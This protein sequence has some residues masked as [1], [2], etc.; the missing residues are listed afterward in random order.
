VDGGAF[1]RIVASDAGPAG[2]AHPDC[3][4]TVRNAWAALFAAV[5]GGGDE[6]DRPASPRP[7]PSPA[8]RAAAAALRLCQGVRLATRADAEGL[9]D[10]LSGAFDYLAMGDYPHPSSYITNGDGLLPAYPM[11]AACEAAV[12]GRRHPITGPAALAALADAV[13][14]FYNFSGALPCYDPGAGGDSASTDAD[15][16]LWGYQACTEQVMPMWRDGVADLGP[17]APWDGDAF[18][19]ACLATYGVTPRPEW[20]AIQWGGRRLDGLTNVA[21]TNGDLDPWSGTGVTGA[22]AA[23]AGL[24]RQSPTL[25]V[26]P[27]PG[28]AHHL[29]LMFSTPAD[30]PAV[31]AARATTREHMRRWVTEARGRRVLPGGG[32]GVAVA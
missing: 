17:A 27:V 7:K 4:D 32:E 10:F 14:V 24:D 8:A 2:G 6:G 13:G 20:A 3:G 26:V 15:G 11:R 5:E 29:D 22:S 30:P 23:A 25:A 28:G 9:A 18:G 16:W 19:A 12:G 21:F 1:A 31:T